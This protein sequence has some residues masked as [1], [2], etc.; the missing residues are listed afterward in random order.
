MNFIHRFL[1]MLVLFIYAALE[2]IDDI[3]IREDSLI[4]I[5]VCCFFFVVVPRDL[6]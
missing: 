4:F 1:L 3:K 6:E 5:F 2:R